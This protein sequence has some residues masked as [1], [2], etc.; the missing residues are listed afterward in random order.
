[1]KRYA[2]GHS[3]TVAV[4]IASAPVRLTRPSQT[5]QDRPRSSTSHS[6][7]NT[8]ACGRLERNQIWALTSPMISVSDSS[9]AVVYVS[10]SGRASSAVFSTRPLPR[11]TMRTPPTAGVG[12]AGS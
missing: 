6:R 5:F 10:T 2:V 11:L 3:R 1:L 9:G 12:F 7:T 4:V 8:S